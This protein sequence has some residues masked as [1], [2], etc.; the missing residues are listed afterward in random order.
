MADREVPAGLADLERD[1]F[2]LVR[3]ALDADTVATWKHKLYDLHR[4]GLNEID[5]SVGNV[6]FESLLRLEPELSR[7]LIGHPSVAPYLKAMLGRQCQLRRCARTSTRA[8]T[9]RSGT[10]TS[11]TTTTRSATPGRR[12]RCARC[13]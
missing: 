1:G 5:N 9:A 4:R 11:P 12:A 3:G 2:L 7:G 13:A 10:W 6:A 8:P